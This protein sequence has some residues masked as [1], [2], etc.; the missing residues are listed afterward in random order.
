MVVYRPYPTLLTAKHSHLHC[1]ELRRSIIYSQT[2]SKNFFAFNKLNLLLWLNR[3]L[4]LFSKPIEHLHG[5]M[6]GH[7]KPAITWCSECSNLRHRLGQFLT[8]TFSWFQNQPNDS[9]SRFIGSV[10]N[11]ARFAIEIHGMTMRTIEVNG[12][13]RVPLFDIVLTAFQHHWTVLGI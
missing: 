12:F 4:R 13:V 11:T 7:S 10:I 1:L 2:F 5:L 8:E 3:N 9:I 6:V